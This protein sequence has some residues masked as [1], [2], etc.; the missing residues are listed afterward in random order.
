M[1][2]GIYPHWLDKKITALVV[3]LV[4]S[5]WGLYL[6]I[7]MLASRDWWPDEINQW[8]FTW[9]PLRPFWERL[10]DM[11]ATCFQGDYLLTYPF[12]QIFGRHQWGVAIPHIIAT[13]IGFYCLYLICRRY[14]KSTFATA[15]AFLMYAMNTELIRHAFE[16]RP[17]A[18][19]PTLALAVFYCT[20][21]I[22]RSQYALTARKK[23][24]I[25]ALLC[26]TILFHA[27]G[28]LIVACCTLF[29]VLDER[30]T[31]AWPLISKRIGK[32]Y[33]I[34]ALISLP[35]W[36][37]YISLNLHH[38]PTDVLTFEY[39]PNPLVDMGQFFRSIVGNLVGY[40]PFYLFLVGPLLS[41]VLPYNSRL[42]QMGFLLALIILP[43]LVTYVIEINAQYYFIQRQ[44]I[45]VIALCGFYVA[46][47]WDGVFYYL[48]GKHA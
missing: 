2:N 14:L 24:F 17:Y 27:C 4:I 32:F 36:F 11:E 34:V 15:V 47:C 43:I 7:Q 42:R 38:E 9:G 3:A 30:G 12:V 39:I 33:G 22:I 8:N 5:A 19:L 46:W 40:K 10:R 13:V 25:G 35:I 37:W 44:F 20:E 45:W 21:T 23:F 6:R 26:F 41:F 48:G 1:N 31:V 28:I 16:L 29:S 18:V